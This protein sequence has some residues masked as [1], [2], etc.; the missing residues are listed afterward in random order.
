MPPEMTK[1]T[2]QPCS[3]GFQPRGCSPFYRRGL[4]WAQGWR[5]RVGF[6]AFSTPNPAATSAEN[7]LQPPAGMDG[8]DPARKIAPAHLLEA[9]LLHHV[10]EFLLRRE[11]ANAFDQISVGVAIAGN[12]LTQAG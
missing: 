1:R 12:D 7:A 9:R 5:A 10:G 6:V 2:R 8:G 11:T 3:I 4:V